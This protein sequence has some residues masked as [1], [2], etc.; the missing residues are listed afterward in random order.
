M[1]QLPCGEQDSFLPPK[2]NPRKC[3]L[4]IYEGNGDYKY[5]TDMY[6]L[7]ELKLVDL[8]QETMV[9]VQFKVDEDGIVEVTAFDKKNPDNKRSITL[10]TQ[11][12]D[13]QSK[14]LTHIIRG[15]QWTDAE[16]EKY[17]KANEKYKLDRRRDRF[18]DTL[19]QYEIFGDN[20]AFQNIVA[21]TEALKNST[22]SEEKLDEWDATLHSLTSQDTGEAWCWKLKEKLRTLRTQCSKD[23]LYNEVKEWFKTIDLNNNI[24]LKQFKDRF[25]ELECLEI[26]IESAK[27]RIKMMCKKYYKAGGDVE[28]AHDLMREY[29]AH[30]NAMSIVEL[31]KLETQLSVYTD[32]IDDDVLQPYDLS[33]Q[34]VPENEAKDNIDESDFQRR[35][36]KWREQGNKLLH[37]L[38]EYSTEA[39]TEEMRG[40]LE[41]TLQEEVK[42]D[43]IDQAIELMRQQREEINNCIVQTDLRNIIQEIR[44]FDDENKYDEEL[45]ANE[46]YRTLLELVEEDYAEDTTSIERYSAYVRIKALYKN[47]EKNSPLTNRSKKRKRDNDNKE[48]G[49]PTKKQKPNDTK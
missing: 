2:R 10:C 8:K 11:S 38:S 27:E 16:N 28:E 4:L 12:G 32:E 49:P 35:S 6:K 3:T 43:T 17:E 40:F 19:R 25:G 42:E 41:E 26:Q 22:V 14:I 46:D 47:F 24:D 34:T 15:K 45:Q 18:M 13:G 5:E 7:G 36:R 9:V 44:T 37:L 33:D 48:E 29:K 23:D 20:V 1:T 39:W 31:E 30:M 21:E